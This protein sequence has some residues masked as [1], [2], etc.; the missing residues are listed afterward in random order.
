[1]STASQSDDLALFASAL[2]DDDTIKL[3]AYDD[4]MMGFA[5][6]DTIYGYAGKD[7]VEGGEGSDRLFG[8]KGADRL[9]GGKGADDF[10]FNDGETG[11]GSSARDIIFD[12]IKGTDDL[13]L[14]LIDAN[15]KKSGDQKF[16]FGG[17]SAGKNDVWY[18]KSGSD[19]IVY[20][21]TNGDGKADFEIEL[22]GVS[23]LSSGDF[24]L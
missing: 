6:K 9:Y 14:S 20:G 19:T 12:F 1:M 24:I 18:K 15:S 2:S 16:D 4:R 3:S 21:D 22:R 5:G 10:V 11:E 8:G 23:S 17:R 7:T 13:D